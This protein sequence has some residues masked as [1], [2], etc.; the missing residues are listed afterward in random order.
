LLGTKYAMV[1][2]SDG[3]DEIST[4]SVT[5]IVELRDGQIVSKQVN[6]ADF[7][8][9]PAGVEQL[10]VTDAKTSAEVLRGILTGKEK[11]PRRDIVILNAAAAIMAGGLA[12]D[13]ESAINLARTSVSE[14]R[15]MDCLERLIEVS[16]A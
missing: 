3:M 8:F 9:A 1:V 11:G 4:V 10:K 16:N 6:P 5:K 15:A 13:F 2:H 12:D 14:G 7:G